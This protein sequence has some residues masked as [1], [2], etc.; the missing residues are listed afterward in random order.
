MCF[1]A[2][3]GNP[4]LISLESLRDRGLLEND[5]LEAL[6]AYPTTI[7]YGRVIRE[8]TPLLRKAWANFKKRSHQDER[9]ELEGFFQA[10]AQWLEDFALF[11]ALKE[12]H[13]GK[14]WIK[15]SHGLI[16]RRPETI[17]RIKRKHVNDIGFH[18]F[19]QFEFHRQISALK[20]YANQRGISIIGDL[21]IYVAHDS[22]EVWAQPEFFDINLDTGLPC[23]VSGVP[24]DY[25][26]ATGQL[27]GNPIYNWDRLKSDGYEWWVQRFKAL[28]G[29]VDAVRIDHFRGFESYW[30]I[31]YGEPTA[32]KGEWV[33]APGEELFKRLYAHFGELP[34]IAEDL[35]VITPEVEKLRDAFE[36]PGMKILQFAF[37]DDND[38]P[39]LPHNYNEN[40]VVYTGTH[41]N[42]TTQGWFQS[43]TEK[44]RLAVLDYLGKKRGEDIHWDMIDLAYSSSAKLAIIPMQDLLGLGGEARMNTPSKGHG[45][46]TWRFRGE[47]VT[48]DL[49]QRLSDLTATTGRTL[50]GKT[51]TLATEIN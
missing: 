31:K 3:A 11:M 32:I 21:P 16:K 49:K 14:S 17:K 9:S 22:A 20:S 40:C 10:N 43:L 33:I 12:L 38:N 7:D 48:E 27:W 47:W 28:L 23:T 2:M 41:D 6:P 18:K 44:E 46:W 35:G 37:G 8:K 15:W 30:R 50:D 34:V 29:Y 24:P 51:T 19:L 5:D 13:H 45:N 4:L 42:D 1:S 25:F 26:S 39:Y 36:L